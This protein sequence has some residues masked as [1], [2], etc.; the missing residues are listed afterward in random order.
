MP[1]SASALARLSAVW[2]PMVGQ[3]RVR[4]LARDDLLGGLD[5]DG[6][7]VRPVGELRV[8][9]HRGGVAVEQ[10]HLHALLP[11]RL[12]GL[13]AG[14]VE[15]DGLADDDRARSRSTRTFRMSV[16]LGIGGVPVTRSTDGSIGPCP[17]TPRRA[18]RPADQ[19]LTTTAP[20]RSAQAGGEV[21]QPLEAL[22][23][24][25]APGGKGEPEVPRRAE[26]LTG[27]RRDQQNPR[28][29]VPRRRGPS[30]AS[31]PSSSCQ[32][33]RSRPGTRRR[34]PRAGRSGRRGS[35]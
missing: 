13:G 9:H 35:G 21:P 19:E 6:L 28:G 23:Q 34:P 31:S 30:G 7:D 15:L 27:H 10:H 2:P 22:L 14:V 32:S 5:G 1:C 33:R 17:D 4:A 24:R 16:R 12:D 26:R 11:E 25:F 3:E 20:A 18:D 8:R 29:A